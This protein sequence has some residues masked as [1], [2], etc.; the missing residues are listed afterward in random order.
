MTAESATLP[1][2]QP[3]AALLWPERV[4]PMTSGR[5]KQNTERNELIAARGHGYYPRFKQ[6]CHLLIGDYG[7]LPPSWTGAGNLNPLKMGDKY[8]DRVRRCGWYLR[9]ILYI[10]ICRLR[11]TA[12]TNYFRPSVL[13]RCS[14]TRLTPAVSDTST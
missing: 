11:D 9:C 4:Y 10:H 8:G 3:L 14:A 1:E 2:G 7:G 5:I 13:H 6:L 12:K